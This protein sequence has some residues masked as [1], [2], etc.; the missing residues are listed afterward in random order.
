MTDAG[1]EDVFEADGGVLELRELEM[2]KVPDATP[3]E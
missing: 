1:A 3:D 2:G